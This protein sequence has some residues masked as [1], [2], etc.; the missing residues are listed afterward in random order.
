[1]EPVFSTFDILSADAQQASC[2]ALS[3]DAKV[4]AILGQFFN[5][6]SYLCATQ[7]HR[8]PMITLGQVVGGDIYQQAG[9]LLFTLFAEGNR[10]MARFA[11]ELDRA[12]LLADRTIGVVSDDGYDPGGQTANALI[13]ALKRFQADIGHHTHFSSD[14]SVGAS[15]VPVEVQA[16]R[17]NRVDTVLLIASPIYTTQ[18]VHEADSQLYQLKYVTSDWAAMGTDVGQRNMPDSYDGT[19]NFV[20]N[21]IGDAR[22]G[23]P[24]PQEQVRCRSIYE[25]F[26]G[27]KLTRH[28]ALRRGD[29]GM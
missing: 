10:M 24:E 18:F 7:D 9:G 23:R 15:Q 25:K 5:R 3:E 4:F 29:V 27:E 14:L 8:R 2:L 1:M 16:M 17:A 26:T 6:A 20:T 21:Y 11:G 19:L 22:I 13:G 12:G 28:D